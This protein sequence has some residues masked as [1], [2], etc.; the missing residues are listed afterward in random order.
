ME[1]YLRTSFKSDT[2]LKD[3]YL[4]HNALP[5]LNFD[6]IDTSMEFL[7][8]KIDY[9]IIINAMTGGTKFAGEIN[10]EL[11]LLAREFNIP[12]AVGSETI[13]ICEED[14]CRESFKITDRR[15]HV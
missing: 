9:P 2:L 8:K 11:S 6:E 1:N 10:K 5:E 3:V 14:S 7:G 12:M 4:E 15:A 13:I